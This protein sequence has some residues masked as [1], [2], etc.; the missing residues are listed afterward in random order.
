M[1]C[2]IHIFTVVCFGHCHSRGMEPW[3]PNCEDSDRNGLCLVLVP[4]S[5]CSFFS[6]KHFVLEIDN[7]VYSRKTGNHCKQGFG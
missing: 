3:L 6:V 1:V 5:I 2:V 7:G 4:L